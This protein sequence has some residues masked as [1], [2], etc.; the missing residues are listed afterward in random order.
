MKKAREN[1]EGSEREQYAELRDYLN[2]ILLSN[3]GSTVYLDTTLMPDSLPLFKRVYI[4]FEACKKG[5]VLGCRPFIG[6]DGT[7]LKGFYGG[8]LLNAIGQD[9]NNQIFPI[10]YAVVD[11]KTRDNWKW[12]LENLHNDLGNYKVH[13]WNFISDQQ[14]GLIPAM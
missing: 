14:K 9:T 4:S 7:F 2:Q 12:F 3:P 6:L 1:I 11:S 8:Q 13:G 5:F 10:A